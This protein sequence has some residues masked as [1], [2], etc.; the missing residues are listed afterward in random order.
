MR[1]YIIN[2]ILD[3]SKIEAG[4]L[5]IENTNFNLHQLLNE[6]ALLFT[7]PAKERGLPIKTEIVPNVP[8]M[9]GG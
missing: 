5:D 3:Y 6:C 1:A 4:K 9:D 8:E 2:D 7:L